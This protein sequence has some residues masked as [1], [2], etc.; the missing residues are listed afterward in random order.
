M[1][2]QMDNANK[3]CY[4]H[5]KKNLYFTSAIPCFVMIS[6][7]LKR[8]LTFITFIE[9]SYGNFIY[10]YN[11]NYYSYSRGHYRHPEY[12]SLAKQVK[13]SSIFY[14]NNSFIIDL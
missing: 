13:C 4:I 12:H 9:L 7:I 1:D 6:S 2:E 14:R 3:I 8:K 11:Y 10:N 5:N